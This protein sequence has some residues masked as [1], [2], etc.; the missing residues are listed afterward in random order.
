MYN[1]SGLGPVP[2]V[3]LLFN[4]LDGHH[5]RIY[6]AM[7]GRVV[8][9]IVGDEPDSHGL[10]PAQVLATRKGTLAPYVVLTASADPAVWAAAWKAWPD[11]LAFD[12]YPFYGSIGQ[13][14]LNLIL[15]PWVY[16]RWRGQARIVLVQA[17]RDEANPLHYHL[18]PR[19]GVRLQVWMARRF[20]FLPVLYEWQSGAALIASVLR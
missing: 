3:A 2:P 8:A 9:E 5:D 20:G 11:W 19:W 1:F 18:P 7:T 15:L 4:W 14:M 6:D 12:Y 10:S 13:T 16:R 17:F